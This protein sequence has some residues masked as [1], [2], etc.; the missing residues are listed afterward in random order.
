MGQ[1][2]CTKRVKFLGNK[3]LS[4]C[5]IGDKS[6]RKIKTAGKEKSV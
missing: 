2:V 5:L 6:K 1:Y 4:I 3:K